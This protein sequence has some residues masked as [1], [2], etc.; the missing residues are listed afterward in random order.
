MKIAI[1]G[2]AGRMGKWFTQYFVEKGHVLTVSG[3]HQEKLKALAK[4]YGVKIAKNNLEAVKDA[5]LTLVSVPI[6]KTAEVLSEITP[7]LKRGSIVSEIASVKAGIIDVLKESSKFGVQPLSLH[8]LFG[9]MQKVKKKFAL[10]PVLDAESE[11]AVAKRFFPDAEIVVVDAEKHDR[12][13]AITLSLQ[14]FVNMAFASTVKDEDFKTLEKL[15]GT[16]FTLQQVLIGAIM[17]QDSE[18]HASLHMA[19]KHS[20][21]YLR[22]FVSN[23][24]KII[25]LIESGDTKAFQ[26]FYNG[27]SKG[28]SKTLDLAKMYQKMYAILEAIEKN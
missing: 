10:V 8:P 18:L 5:D 22:K 17:M 28:L 12:A 25:K 21:E 2:A 15:S 13:M 9:P 26:N 11:L 14:Y 23:A 19:N 27:I 7:K 20:P 16:T 6:G 4:D 24:E 3:V 1:L